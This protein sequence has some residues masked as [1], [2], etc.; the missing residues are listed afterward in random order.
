MKSLI[1]GF[2]AAEARMASA[3]RWSFTAFR[4]TGGG[5]GADPPLD[6]IQG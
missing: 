2:S 4:A 1:D 5:R 6:R 3:E